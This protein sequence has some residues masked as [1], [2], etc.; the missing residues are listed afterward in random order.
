[1]N[2][3]SRCI[4]FAETNGTGAGGKAEGL[5]TLIALGLPVP[6][7]FVILNPTPNSLPDDLEQAYDRLGRGR[8]AVRSSAS[9][10]DGTAVSFAGQ[11]AT[12]LDVEGVPALRDAVI[13]CINSLTSERAKAYRKER[14]DSPNGTMSV[15][16]QRMVDARSAG[17]IFTADPTTARRDR[18]VVEAVSGTGDALMSGTVTADHFTLDRNGTV[19]KSD[20]LGSATCVHDDE[21]KTLASDALRIEQH[22]GTPV[23]CEWAIDREGTIAWL[24]ARPITTLPADPRELDD[25]LNPDDIYSRC[26]VGEIFPGVATPLT[27]ST[28]VRAMDKGMTRPYRRITTLETQKEPVLCFVQFGRLF[29]NLSFLVGIVRLMPGGS[30]AYVTENLCGRPVPEIVPGPRAP[31]SERIRNG[32]RYVTFMLFFMLFGRHAARLEQILSSVDLTPGATV[33]ETYAKIDHELPKLGEGWFRHIASTMLPGTL[34]GALPQLLAKGAQPTAQHS[35]VMAQVLTGTTDVES[36]DIA[37]GINRIVAALIEY[38]GP[39]LERFVTLNADEGRRFLEH[40]AS[41]PTRQEY[42][43]YLKRHGHRCI[44]E[45]E[46][47]EKEWAEDPTPIVDAVQSG[48]R[49]TRAGHVRPSRHELA[50]VPLLVRMFVKIGQRGIRERETT[51]SQV[52]LLTTLFKR[53]YRALARQ[54]VEEGLLPDPDLVFFLQHAELG[55]LRGPDSRLVEKAIARRKV[56][57]YQE[58][59]YFKEN[60]RGAP[61]P[62]NPPRPSGEGILHGKPASLGIVRGRA[63]VVQTFT[64]A[65]EVQP[66]EILIVP[67][68]DVGWTPVLATIAGFASDVGSALSHGAVV[69]REYGIP[70]VVNLRKATRTFH[71]GDYVELDADHGVLRRIPEKATKDQR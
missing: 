14:A 37:E 36:V 66:N 26:N 44:L 63:R 42:A 51:K 12:V 11:H 25:E 48:V 32:F 2:A 38:D 21:L 23:D 49:A 59:F 54:M 15:I 46:L 30:D 29:F 24:Q 67:V 34:V 47:R 56:L 5:S 31:Q 13:H 20:L 27:I 52:I 53:A 16:V 57:P 19:V 39:Q 58:K 10:E 64:E 71:T 8:V 6:D 62:I 65:S 61:E 70:A 33:R 50:S 35:A 45:M 41:A 28:V 7:G 18:M 4:P 1:M 55:E 9:D 68:I 3:R 40:E 22:V 60:S 17:A 69:A 43:A